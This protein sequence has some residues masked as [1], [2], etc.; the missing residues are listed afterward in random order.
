MGRVAREH[1]QGSVYHVFQRGNNR[2]FLF[3][4]DESKNV[5]IKN[6]REFKQKFDYDILGY[7]VMNNH[8]H[9]IIKINDDPLDKI[10]FNINN[11]YAKY[12]NKALSRSGHVFESRYNC[13]IVDSEGYLLWLLRY[14][15]RN[16]IRAKMVNSMDEYFWSSHYFYKNSDVET[17]DTSFILRLI[18]NKKARAVLGYMKY[19]TSLGD[20]ENEEEDYKILSDKFNYKFQNQELTIRSGIKN[21][22]E[23]LKKIADRI[24]NDYRTREL[25]ITGSRQRY[26]TPLKLDFINAARAL[27]YSIA[28]IA[29][30]LNCA[31]SSISCLLGRNSK[32]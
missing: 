17:I 4:S 30:H 1:K 24:F 16:P 13:K 11:V 5:L 26:L 7:V 14:I 12:I 19:M 25:I 8:Y 20:D 2:E 9:I 3:E 18:S 31:E 6:F 22:R 21:N 28:E 29:E 27:N 23:E 10:M 15:H 32:I